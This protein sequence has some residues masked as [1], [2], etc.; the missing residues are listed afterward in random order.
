MDAAAPSETRRLIAE[1]WLERLLRTYPE[2]SSRILH[3]EK[4]PFRNPIGHAFKE[5][6][7]ILVEE[8]FGG[9]NAARIAA[10]MDSIVRIRAVQDFTA[11]Q[12]V[13]FVF[14]LREIAR[15]QVPDDEEILKTLDQRVDELALI[16]FDLFTSCREKL[17][18]IKAGELKRSMYVQLRRECGR[19]VQ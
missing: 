19:T 6:L 10:A 12:T 4:D 5:G 13:S 1:R 8:V 17:C 2:N 18:E 3:V 11:R 16:A 14:L 9:M 15:E 7:S